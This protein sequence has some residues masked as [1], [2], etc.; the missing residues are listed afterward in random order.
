[1]RVPWL[2]NDE[3]VYDLKK[4]II[5]TWNKR[6]G[7]NHTVENIILMGP[8]VY[9]DI[10]EQYIC[11]DDPHVF[12]ISE[13]RNSVANQNADCSNDIDLVIKPHQ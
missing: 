5:P 6:V 13:I 7:K 2:K 9:V 3:T 4:R 10:E 8:G 11:Y 1:M 12:N